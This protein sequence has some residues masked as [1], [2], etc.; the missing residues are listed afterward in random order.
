MLYT[1]NV[2]CFIKRCKNS[3]Y[4]NF[5]IVNNTNDIDMSLKKTD[6][7]ENEQ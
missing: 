5:K 2:T 6:K 4:K 3:K 7:V 1:L